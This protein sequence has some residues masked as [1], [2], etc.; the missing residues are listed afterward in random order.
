MPQ[1][2]QTIPKPLVKPNIY[3]RDA[4]R[5]IKSVE[6]KWDI[7]HADTE[8]NLVCS[9]CDYETSTDNADSGDYCPNCDEGE[10]MYNE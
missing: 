9:H 10:L 3:N 2:I 5:A 6:M 7:L 8:N 4:K 1:E